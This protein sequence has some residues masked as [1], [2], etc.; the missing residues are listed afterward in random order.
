MAVAA[1][2]AAPDLLEE[3]ASKLN[4][5]EE[6]ARQHRH[7]AWAVAVVIAIV[8]GACA[9]EAFAFSTPTTVKAYAPTAIAGIGLLYVVASF[10]ALM[11]LVVEISVDTDVAKRVKSWSRARTTI[12]FL[13]LAAGAICQFIA[14]MGQPPAP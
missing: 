12:S 2:G 13:V 3:F 8:G 11:A 1:V 9:V 14:V 10:Y 7:R 5:S 4:V 6:T